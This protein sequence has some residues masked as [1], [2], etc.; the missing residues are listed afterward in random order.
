MKNH[1]AHAAH[2]GVPLCNSVSSV[3]KDFGFEPV[4]LYGI[5]RLVRA[6]LDCVSGTLYTLLDATAGFRGRRLRCVASL[7][8]GLFSVLGRRF[9]SA[10]GGVAGRLCGF[11]SR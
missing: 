10:L 5:G 6:L 1:R 7:V 8:R 4:L 2:R 3:V 11:D 9:G